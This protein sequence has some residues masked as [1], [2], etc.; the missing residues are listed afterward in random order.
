MEG[1]FKKR[2]VQNDQ[3]RDDFEDIDTCSDIYG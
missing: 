1:I 2:D 3:F